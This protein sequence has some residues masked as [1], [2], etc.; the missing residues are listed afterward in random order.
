M[1]QMS[2]AGLAIACLAP[3]LTPLAH[4]QGV[5]TDAQLAPVTVTGS[6]TR[7]GLPAAVPGSTA[8]KTADQLRE[9]NLFNPEDALNYVP[10]TVVRKRYL[11][12]RNALLA[13]RSFGTLQPSRALVYLDGYLI[14][15]FLG[16]FDAPRW[17]MI[18]PEAIAR[19]DVLYGP[20]SALF[21]GNSIGTTV[22]VSQ[23][24]PQGFELSGRL[25]A[26]S[27]HFKQYGQAERFDSGQF[28][29]HVANRLDGGAWFSAD[30]NH[31]DAT[32]QPMQWQTVVA[33]AAGSFPAVTGAATTV[34][35]IVY[36]TDPK[37]LKR[38]VFGANGGAIDHT[39]QDTLNL[40][41]GL[42]LTPTLEAS[43]MASW[44]HNDTETRNQS[45]LRDAA[46]TTVWS[47]VV[48]DGTNR[49]SIPASAFAPSTR[50]ETHQQLGATLKT[51]RG[52]GWNGSL[53]VSDYRLLTDNARQA[54]TP[55]P[56]AAAGGAGSL[57]RRDGTGW[58]TAEVQASYTPTA[59][60]WGHGRHAL[61]LGLHR[62]G[63][64]LENRVAS[65][66]DWRG[67][68]GTASQFYGGKTE[69]TALYLQDAWRFSDDWMLTLGW[70]EERFQTHSGRQL[71]GGVTVD[72]P[73]RSLRGHSPK[74]ALAWA[75][76]DSL[77]LKASA[78]RGVRFPNVEELYNGTV[79]ATS[80]TLSDPT[81]K[82]ET[83]DAV[84]LS[85]EFEGDRQRLRVSLYWD[86]VRDA[87][88]RQSTTDA[89]VCKTTATGASSYTCVQNVDRV[90][91]Q[92][93]ELAWQAQDL[94]LKGLALEASATYTL[95]S[96]VTANARDPA[97]VG[98]W[99][100]RVPRTRAALQASYRPDT[101]WLF[102]AG[103][104]HQGRAYNDTYNLDVN[105]NVYGG[106]S[107]LNQLDLRGAYKF[108][109]QLELA[110]GINNLSDQHAYQ[111][112][113]YP[114]RTLFAE[115]R[116]KR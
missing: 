16:R 52:P 98:K 69:I 55:D 6:A 107:K 115:L 88:L 97:M 106:V 79:T 8:S 66:A 82:A 74:A 49:F 40:R 42:M 67:G 89:A 37:G 5:A 84:D 95:R 62:N 63:Y 65:L 105:P 2:L 38:A 87:I 31:Q 36:D 27:Q 9:Q 34:T 92:G 7:N 46:G 35:G 1:T 3:A 50:Q 71:G 111:S 85:A 21:P 116:F 53:V 73:G 48:T 83:A 101:R 108:T 54:N 57:T 33:N 91:T 94:G 56:V 23:R 86:D 19:V 96:E 110:L 10:G 58:N 113:P 90:Q 81:L 13:G 64:R 32:G 103:W 24:V 112:H 59:G 114:G 51:R 72:Y 39:V 109:P 28:S 44:W 68:N 14:S 20:Y 99:W 25:V 104:R 102:A 26:S 76:S 93:I 70:R 75:A 12:D 77:T 22:A 60:D 80:Q 18:S 43:V 100:L 11:G 47:G 61:A 29:L 4:A 78:G 45:W 30:L 17:N 15:N 41:G